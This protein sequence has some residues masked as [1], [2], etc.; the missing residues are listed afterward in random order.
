MR[1]G[2]P[3]SRASPATNLI[4]DSLRR[5]PGL[6]RRPST[7]AS[8]AASAISWWKW[9]SAMIGTGGGQGVDLGQRAF[10]VRRFGGGHRLDRYRGAVADGHVTD[11]DPAGPPAR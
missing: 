6:S 2:T 9:M 11:G 4:S 10:D 1:M 5:L 3:R 8:S 7:P